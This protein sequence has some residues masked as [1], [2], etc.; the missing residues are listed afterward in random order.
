MKTTITSTLLVSAL[1]VVPLAGCGN[2][3][4][5]DSVG[6]AA[7]DI[8]TQITDAAAEAV[9]KSFESQIANLDARLDT[10]KAQARELADDAL[11]KLL[12]KAED[13]LTAA[14]GEM[15]DLMNK[16]AQSAD[17]VEAEITELLSKVQDFL[18]QAEAR[19][20]QLGG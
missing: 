18:S 9:S 15:E 2:E 14:R 12:R 7:S 19:I 4:G 13:Q 8:G 11:T 16:T 1:L 20:A 6:V 17:A 5:S 3:E 10:L